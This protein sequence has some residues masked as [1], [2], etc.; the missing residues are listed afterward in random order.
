MG[1]SSKY[2]NYATGNVSINGNTVAS[3]SKDNNTIN[4]SYNMT[5]LEKSIY[6][7]VQSNLSQSLSNLFSISDEKQK[8]W[9][10]SIESKRQ[11]EY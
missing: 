8:Q 2:P 1:K 6:D 11:S 7:G 5:D 4:S 3:T 9:N 10:S